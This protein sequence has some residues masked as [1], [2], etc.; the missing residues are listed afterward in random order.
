MLQKHY[1]TSPRLVQEK[2]VYFIFVGYLGERNPTSWLHT[3]QEEAVYFDRQHWFSG[4][5]KKQA[6]EPD[7]AHDQRGSAAAATAIQGPPECL[8]KARGLGWHP[9]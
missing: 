9:V 7:T 4:S 2:A 8:P 6:H 1:R 5:F 3:I